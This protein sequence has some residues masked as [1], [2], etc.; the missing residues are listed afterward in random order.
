ML[1]AVQ[2]HRCLASARLHGAAGET[3][4]RY[5]PLADMPFALPNVRF[6]GLRG[7]EIILSKPGAGALKYRSPEGI[8]AEIVA[9]GR[10]EEKKATHARA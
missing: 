9:E 10:Y 8:I 5:W 1:A 2:W 6:R 3:N 7:H 4:V